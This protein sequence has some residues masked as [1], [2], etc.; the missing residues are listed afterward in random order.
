MHGF[1]GVLAR[2]LSL[3]STGVQQSDYSVPRGFCGGPVWD[4]LTLG[5][6]SVI[7]RHDPM[8]LPL[9]R[10]IESCHCTRPVGGCTYSVESQIRYPPSY[11]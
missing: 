2:A 6:H 1:G 10:V 7:Q 9:S 3:E 8:S 11:Y 5:I 4:D